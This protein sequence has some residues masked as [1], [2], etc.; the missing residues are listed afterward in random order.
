MVCALTSCEK[1]LLYHI[2]QLFTGGWRLFSVL[3]FFL[4]VVFF[5]LEL[6][7]LAYLY[8]IFSEGDIPLKGDTIL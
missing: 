6:S 4:I 1:Y 8:Q 5:F 2:P 3:V 7:I